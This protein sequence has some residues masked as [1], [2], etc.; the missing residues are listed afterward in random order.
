[1]K[2]SYR[3]R[4]IRLKYFHFWMRLRRYTEISDSTVHG[5]GDI[6][7]YSTWRWR[8]LT[9][10]GYLWLHL[11]INDSSWR[12]LTPLG[13]IWLHLEASDSTWRYKKIP[14]KFRVHDKAQS[15][16]LRCTSISCSLCV[17]CKYLR[18]TETLCK[19]SFF[20]C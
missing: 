3:L 17:Y 10:F 4:T 14:S 6:W 8:Y 15:L 19:A 16:T 7:L 5:D 1:M 2:Y 18:Q 9:Q 11:E 13:G 12:N 20:Y